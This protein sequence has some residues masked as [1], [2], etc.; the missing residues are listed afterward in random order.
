VEHELGYITQFPLARVEISTDQ[1]TLQLAERHTACLALDKCKPA[2]QPMS[3]LNPLKFNFRDEQ[4]SSS[5][6]SEK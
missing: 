2:P 1:V 6:C 4:P 5:C 3:D